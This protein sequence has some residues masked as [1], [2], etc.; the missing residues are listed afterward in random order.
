MVAGLTSISSS[1]SCAPSS[2]GAPPFTELLGE[3][4]AE[5]RPVRGAVP[6]LSILLSLY[7]YKPAPAAAVDEA[8]ASLERWW[9]GA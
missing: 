5:S 8:L 1:S 4:P 9:P 6:F 7:P 2:L 3:S